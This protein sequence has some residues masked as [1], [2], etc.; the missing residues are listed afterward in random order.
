MSLAI[1]VEAYSG[2]RAN[3]RPLR[4]SV[5]PMIEEHGGVSGV[6]DIEAIEDRWYDPHAEY[7]KVRT[8]DGKRYILRY[9]ER[10]NEWTLRSG[11]DGD[12]LLARPGTVVIGDFRGT[13]PLR[14]SF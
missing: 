8:T 7:F 5:D 2:H 12:E 9:D 14:Y 1:Y 3:E 10:Q 11:L 13:N 6:F 4:F